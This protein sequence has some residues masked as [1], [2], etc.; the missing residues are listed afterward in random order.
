MSP[1]DKE[2]NVRVR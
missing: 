1:G 2:L